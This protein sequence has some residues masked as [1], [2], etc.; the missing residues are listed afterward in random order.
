MHFLDF[1]VKTFPK[2]IVYGVCCCFFFFAYSACKLLTFVILMYGYKF[3][4]RI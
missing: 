3:D 1:E 4:L 2:A